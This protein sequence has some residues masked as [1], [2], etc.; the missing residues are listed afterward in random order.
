[1]PPALAE[2]VLA[3]VEHSG[4]A[5]DRELLIGTGA[6][7]YDQIL[8]YQVAESARHLTT[9]PRLSQL[10]RDAWGRVSQ[11]IDQVLQEFRGAQLFNLREPT[12][13][14]AD[15]YYT[16]P[17]PIA[18]PEGPQSG[19]VQVFWHDNGKSGP[20]IPPR[21]DPQ[22]VR[23][24]FRLDTP[25]LGPVEVDLVILQRRVRAHIRSDNEDVRHLARQH[26]D[27]L[28]QGL[29]RLDFAVEQCRT[30][31]LTTGSPDTGVGSSPAAHPE[32]PVFRIDTV[33]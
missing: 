21:V 24:L 28:R 5:V 20:A 12:A 29:R 3:L 7:R 27:E 10:Q 15:Q 4:I 8:L 32:R 30:S 31:V 6:S 17:L 16:F 19:R 23:L 26:A 9:D 13:H 25:S 11:R 22:D 18:T 1:M 14:A 2:K 33:V